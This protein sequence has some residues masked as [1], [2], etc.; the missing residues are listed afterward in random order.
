MPTFLKD[1]TPL[2]SRSKASPAPP[3]V[4]LNPNGTNIYTIMIPNPTLNA[5]LCVTNNTIKFMRLLHNLALSAPMRL[6]PTHANLKEDFN[7]NVEGKTPPAR[8]SAVRPRSRSHD[9]PNPEAF[10]W[11]VNSS[12]HILCPPSFFTPP[13]CPQ[14]QEQ[15][16]S[17]RLAQ[18]VG[19]PRRA[20]PVVAS[21]QCSDRRGAA[22]EHNH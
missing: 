14:M 6:L 7:F 20:S 15:Y 13:A 19:G 4:Y 22:G 8:S 12:R 21:Q 9:Q 1:V 16:C 11:S 10:C 17:V 3:G 18:G 5:A 2:D